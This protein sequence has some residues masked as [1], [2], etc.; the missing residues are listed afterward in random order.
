M[1]GTAVVW[2]IVVLGIWIVTRDKAAIAT[3]IPST[4]AEAKVISDTIAKATGVV[5]TGTWGPPEPSTPEAPEEPSHPPTW[6]ELPPGAC[7]Y[8]AL[9]LLGRQQVCHIREY[10]TDGEVDIFLIPEFYPEAEGTEKRLI[11][12]HTHWNADSQARA[13]EQYAGIMIY[14]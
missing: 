7:G 5:P 13:L 8:F 1:R 6:L 12:F 9:R 2:V 3:A 14:D 10:R 11:I 4:A